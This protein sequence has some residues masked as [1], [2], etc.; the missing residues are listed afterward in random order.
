MTEL[1]GILAGLLLALQAQPATETNDSPEEQPAPV[2]QAAA[3]VEPEVDEDDKIICRKTAVI[4][5]RFKK[6]VCATKHEWETLRKRSRDNA[7]EMQ[8][9]GK[10]LSPNG[11]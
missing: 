1:N 3:A 9:K 11:G 6:R 4:G 8:R 5:S 7:D 10:G 2:T